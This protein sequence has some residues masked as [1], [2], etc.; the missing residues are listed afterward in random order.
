MRS[1]S[2]VIL[3]PLARYQISGYHRFSNPESKPTID[4]E[5]Q[6]AAL[7]LGLADPLP[8]KSGDNQNRK[9]EEATA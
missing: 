1:C 5:Y 4:R 9:R 7:A 2:L 8:G 3:L 6:R